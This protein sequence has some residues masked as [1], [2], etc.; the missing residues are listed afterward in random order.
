MEQNML[1]QS[2]AGVA[3]SGGLSPEETKTVIDIMMQFFTRETGS[4]KRAAQHVNSI[5]Q[6]IKNP[7]AKLIHIDGIV[8]LVL[9]KERG[10]VEFHTMAGKE[11]SS[12]F[13]KKVTMLEDV[14]R[15]LGVTK[16]YSYTTDPKFKLLVKRSRQPWV[17][18]KQRGADGVNYDVYTL[19]LK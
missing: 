15:N 16:M 11:N 10:V 8:F 2:Q 6:L 5:A 9:V 18:T 4:K 19:E 1:N 17:I 13:I 14:L 12:G 7:A 3:G